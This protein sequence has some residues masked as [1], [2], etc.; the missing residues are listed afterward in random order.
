MVRWGIEPWTS[1]SESQEKPLLL[2]YWIFIFL[3]FRYNFTQWS[4]K[5]DESIN[6]NVSIWGFKGNHILML[7]FMKWISPFVCVMH[8]VFAQTHCHYKP[9]IHKGWNSFYIFTLSSC[10]WILFYQPLSWK[11]LCFSWKSEGMHSKWKSLEKI[12]LCDSNLVII[13]TK[14]KKIFH[15]VLYSLTMHL[16]FE[17]ICNIIILRKTS[18]DNT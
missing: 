15:R 10:V 16:V 14:K 11:W 13:D 4:E 12:V 5:K 7:A 6:V 9:T 8:K 3:I 2:L 1:C 18:S 17:Q